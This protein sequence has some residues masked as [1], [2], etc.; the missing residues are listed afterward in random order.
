MPSTTASQPFAASQ[1]N[2]SSPNFFPSTR[3]TFVAPMFLLPCSRTS[4]PCDFADDQSERNRTE[5]IGDEDDGRD[6]QQDHATAPCAIPGARA[7]REFPEVCGTANR[8]RQL[9]LPMHTSA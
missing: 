8:A 1:K 4:M 5:K 7:S 6:E 3:Q 2:V 9:S